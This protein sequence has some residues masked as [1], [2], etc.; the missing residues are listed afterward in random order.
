ME[1]RFRGLS[2]NWQNCDSHTS[3]KWWGK[4]VHNYG[5]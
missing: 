1:V 3:V 5:N 4:R 2:A